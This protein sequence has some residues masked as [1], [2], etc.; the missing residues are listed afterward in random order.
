MKKNKK[1]LSVKSIDA[2]RMQI[3]EFQNEMEILQERIDK[4][5]KVISALQEICEHKNADGSDAFE[6]E[7]STSHKNRYKCTICGY[8]RSI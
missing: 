1:K 4:F 6:Y 3:N 7:G 2:F 5:R 8:E